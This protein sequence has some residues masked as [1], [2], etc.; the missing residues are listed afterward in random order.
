MTFIKAN[1]PLFL[2]LPFVVLF[3]GIALFAVGSGEFIEHFFIIAASVLGA[4]L[5]SGASY[6]TWIQWRKSQKLAGDMRIAMENAVMSLGAR[7]TFL[8]NMS[9]EIR[10]PLHSIIGMA[11]VLLDHPDEQERDRCLTIIRRAGNLLMNLINDILD[12][13]KIE[14]GKLDIEHVGFNL[15]DLVHQ[16]IE[17]IIFRAHQKGLELTS[18]IEPD[19]PR[20]LMG[21]PNRIRQVLLNL[22]G[23][24]IRF[25]QEGRVELQVEA[26]QDPVPGGTQIDSI[27]F[28]VTDTGVGIAE[29]KQHRVFQ[30]FAQADRATARQYGGTGLGLTISKHLIELMGGKIRFESQVGKGTSFYVELPVIQ[31]KATLSSAEG[32]LVAESSVKETQP[33]R[34]LRILVADDLEENRLLIHLFLRRLPYRLEFAR[35]G[36]EVM[37]KREIMDPFD[38]ILMD[39]HMPQMNGYETTK[40]IRADEAARNLERVPVI[41]LTAHALKEEIAKSLSAGCDRHL[42]KPISA[43][44]LQKAILEVVQSKSKTESSMSSMENVVYI[45]RELSHLIPAFMENRRKEMVQIGE[46]ISRADW[47]AVDGL[48]HT[49]KGVAGTFGFK[50]LMEYGI[51]FQEA[52]KKSEPDVIK[53]IHH[54]ATA[55]LSRLYV[56][57]I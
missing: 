40:N 15:D 54:E 53:K 8:A 7:S 56:T 31:Q 21:D 39:M 52:V 44:N 12:L 27:R 17:M 14:A 24:S 18:K 22:I 36:V 37:E 38:L 55:H 51:G 29:D 11:D 23:N 42:T 33:I 28:R 16:T 10:T 25:T 6:F 30:K 47:P 50:Q 46:A 32:R 57:Y 49:L 9:H 35:N 26:F 2:F 41:A 20:L 1:F 45:R 43:E 4:V 13:S 19:V 48:A 34:P 5:L 3:L